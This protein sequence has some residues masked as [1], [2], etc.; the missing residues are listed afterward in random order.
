MII[1]RFIN[2]IRHQIHVKGPKKGQSEVF[3]ETPGAPDNITPNGNSG[4][5]VGII[6]PALP[7]FNALIDV[8]FPYK[9][10]RRAVTRYSATF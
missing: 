6:A 3:A 9:Y 4:Y 2:S 5:L 1:A 7:R 8:L 10:V